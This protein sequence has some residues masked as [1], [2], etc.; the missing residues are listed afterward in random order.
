MVKLTFEKPSSLVD[1]R[2]PFTDKLQKDPPL[3]QR[4]ELGRGSH[5]HMQGNFDSASPHCSDALCPTHPPIKR[6][7]LFSACY[8]LVFK[9]QLRSLNKPEI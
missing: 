3:S 8:T 6:K 4:G 7:H 1:K 2:S 5:Q 9:G